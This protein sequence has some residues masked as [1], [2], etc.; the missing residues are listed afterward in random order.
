MRV[1]NPNH[2]SYLLRIWKDSDDGEW[3]ATLQDVISGDCFH[4]ATLYE[5]YVNLKEFTREGAQIET[6]ITLE[7]FD[8]LN[9]Q[10]GK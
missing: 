7:P 5:S 3:H 1:R 8:T 4:Y 9:F 6:K 10:A 2:L